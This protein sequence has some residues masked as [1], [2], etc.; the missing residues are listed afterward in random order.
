MRKL[1]ARLTMVALLALIALTPL[2]QAVGKETSL[3]EA[4]QRLAFSVEEDFMMTQGQPL[5]GNPYISDG[6]LL[7]LDTTVCARNAKLLEHFDVVADL[8]LDAV[9]VI[10]A[11]GVAVAFSTEL[12]SP[13][14]GQFTA[15]DLLTTDGV[16]IPNAALTA[17]FD[18]ERDIGLDA[19]HFVGELEGILGFLEEWSQ[20]PGILADMLRQWEIDIW[21]STEGA[22]TA[23]DAIGFLDGDLLSARDGTVVAPGRDLL[24]PG[25]PAGIP[26]RGV[27]FGLD[28]AT[29]S[30]KDNVKT[31]TFST[32]ILHEND[33]GFT[34][35]DVLLYGSETVVHT[36]QQL[37]ASFEPAEG[38]LGLDAFHASP[39][40]QLPPGSYLPLVLKLLRWPILY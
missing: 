2:N 33:F 37:T 35:G 36:N 28:G 15:G 21:F 18:V 24:P 25:I 6:D 39:E 30:R 7:S 9:D 32:E 12:D 13:N 3:P 14:V 11:A 19:I 8:G 26:T 10:S 40:G 5:D 31:L 34:D 23:G 38:F 4:C 17:A 20:E 27:D 29:G 22:W 1:V 16:V